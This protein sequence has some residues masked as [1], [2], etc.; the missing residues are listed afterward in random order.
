MRTGRAS[1]RHW[2]LL[3]ALAVLGVAVAWL[4]ILCWRGDHGRLVYVLDD[5]YISMAVAKNFA[6]HGVW[7]VTPYGFT[8]S[9]STILWPILLA[10]V[11][12]VVG[13]SEFAPFVL[14]TLFACLAVWVSYALLRRFRLPQVYIFAV[15]LA[16]IF[17]TPLPPLVFTGMEH[18]LQ[19]AT[20]VP[21]VYLAAEELENCSVPKP[22]SRWLWVLAPLITL[23]RYEGLFLA[24]AACVLFLLRKRWRYAF[25]LGALALAPVVVYGAISA[26]NGWFWLPNPVYLKA[27]L[28]PAL[29]SAKGTA[30]FAYGRFGLSAKGTDILGLGV[31]T[32]VLLLLSV[33]KNTKFWRR[34]TV[35]AVLF[36]LP[37][38]LHF[39]FAGFGWFYRYEAYL[40]ATSML[41]LA[42]GAHEHAQGL[43]RHRWGKA[44]TFAAALWLIFLVTNPGI[45]LW[46]HCVRAFWRAPRASRNIFEQ[47]YQMG[48]F[49]REFYR[50]QAVAANDIGAVSYLGDPR[51]E[52]LW[53]LGSLDV[54][55]ERLKGYLN[56]E[57]IA[58]LTRAH[59][60]KIAIVYADAFRN[61]FITRT[62]LPSGWRRVGSWTI[63]GNVVCGDSTV[64]FFAVQPSEEPR[65][66]DA[67]KRFSH[68]LP[69]DVRQ[70]GMYTAAGLK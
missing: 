33:V 28:P 51:L 69:R 55:K 19:I 52:D 66:V 20:A 31:A 17:L 70:S 49:V 42:V 67:L 34:E 23:I 32:L 14:A 68:Q 48:L 13:P 64:S 38:A 43:W 12:C 27:N 56:Q 35:M 9:V 60:T 16:I 40:V 22:Q 8:S 29:R 44:H 18:T 57:Q 26:W 39:E 30:P 47:Q 61:G 50:G 53:A 11:Y 24:F 15:L 58:R 54:A 6:L 59:D 46:A 62:G 63:P 3:V 65:L 21:F 1:R 45:V 2:P 10:A 7:G 25:G 4:F 36:L 41:V 5:P 37:A